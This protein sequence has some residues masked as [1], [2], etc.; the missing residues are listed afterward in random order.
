MRPDILWF[1]DDLRL[2]DNP[3]LHAAAAAPS[4]LCVYVLEERLLA[5]LAPGMSERRIGP[6][7]LHFLWQSLCE[8]RGE[9]LKRGSDLLVRVG[10]PVAVLT[11]LASESEARRLWVQCPVASDEASDI[12]RLE[13]RLQADTHIRTGENV[14]LFKASALPFPLSELPETYSAFRRQVEKHCA[15]EDL[16]SSPITLPPWP[17]KMA[18]GMPPL[19]KVCPRATVWRPDP[20]GQFCFEGGEAAGM[21]RLNA[22]LWDKEGGSHYK[23]TRNGL[24]GAD[25][26]TR[27]SAWLA[28]G[29]L[30]PR[31]VQAQVR[32]WEAEYGV[33]ESSYWIVFE[34]LWR[35]YF[36]W[37]ARQEGAGLFAERNLPT[38]GGAFHAWRRGET[39]LPFVDA[40]MIEL[41]TTGWIS[42]RARQNVASFLVKDLGE[43]WRL[44]AA[45]FEHCLI[46]YDVASNWGNWRYVAGVG[47]DPRNRYFNVLKQ[48]RQYDEEGHYVAHWLPALA[49]LPP[50]AVR[51]HPWH[52]EPAR[53]SPPLVM[54]DAWQPYLTDAD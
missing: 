15:F 16:V 2:T 9:L 44:G 38:P 49:S 51:H 7:R 39:G 19:E 32:R 28:R 47:R 1:R 45:W 50:G 29:C 21:A 43:D 54:P 41:A 14:T 35:E 31:Q 12:A 40:A 52:S 34:L 4:L 42:N 5:P 25:F 26:S 20:R 24:L 17:E 6:A 3:V 46:D 22:Y 23:Q 8:L 27:L 30:S 18:R 10:D 37:A 33:S 36:H 13:Q 48:A 53:F 11:D